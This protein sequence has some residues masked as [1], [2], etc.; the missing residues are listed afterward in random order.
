M[1]R[2]DALLQYSSDLNLLYVEDDLEMLEKMGMLFENFFSSVTLAS[3]GKE[4]LD[5]YK[6][7]S[8]DIVLSDIHMPEMNG[9][10]MAKIIK[11]DNPEQAIVFLTAFD[12][13]NYLIDSIDMCIDGYILKPFTIDQVSEV[14]FRVSKSIY[15]SKKELD[16]KKELEKELAKKTSELEQS[17]QHLEKQK[18]RLEAI[19][20][21]SKDGIA[22]LDL[23]SN[24]LDCNDAYLNMTGFNR[25]ELLTK[26]CLGLSTEK[27]TKEYNKVMHEVLSNGFYENCEKTCIVKNN[28][29]ITV[30][31]SLALMPDKTQIVSTIKDITKSNIEAKKIRDY[32]KLIDENISISTTDLEG[33]ITDVSTAFCK[34]SGY[35]KS[36]LIG[37]THKRL[38]DATTPS[39]VYKDMWDSIKADKMWH[40]ELRNKAKDGSHFWMDISVFPIYDGDDV[41]IGYTAIRNDITDKKNIEEISR[42]D[43]LTNIFNRRYFDKILVNIINSAKRNNSSVCFAMFDI[44]FFKSYNDHYGHQKGDDVIIKV[45]QC[46]ENSLKRAD[47]YC[48]RLGGEE[49]G[50][51]FKIDDPKEAYHFIEKIHQKINDQK[52]VHEYSQISEYITTS[53]GLVCKHAHDI[54]SEDAFYK[55]VDD[56]LYISKENGRNQINSNINFSDE[57]T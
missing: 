40:G 19:F 27:D 10:E 35:T 33:N 51:L 32:V 36:E 54:E 28:K 18:N 26:S 44:D 56:L 34:M 38:R 31:M 29:K 25:E 2:A 12:D 50:I 42:R 37:S 53:I 21:T 49:F 11:K 20:Q 43:G 46:L 52:I 6:K 39:S 1:S 8:I 24:F 9:L 15:L 45:A 23:E 57:Q 13:T 55:E 47:D 30:N 17:K 3:N 41:K 48:F 22:I 7:N 14:F 16:Y 5:I 4:A